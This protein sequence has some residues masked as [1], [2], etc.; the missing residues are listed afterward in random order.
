MN[1]SLIPPDLIDV[2]WPQCVPLFRKVEED[3]PTD[4]SVDRLYRYL[5][6]GDNSLIVVSEGTEIVAAVSCLLEELDTGLKVLYFPHIGG[7]KLNLWMDDFMIFADDL[8]RRLGC[9]EIRGM[10]TRRGWLRALKNHGWNEH[11]TVIK[12]EVKYG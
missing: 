4:V 5:K 2:V 10:A 11:Y 7:S 3:T 8:A 1:I 12:H 6:E 9:V